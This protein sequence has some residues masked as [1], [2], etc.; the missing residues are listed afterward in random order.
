MIDLF[1]KISFLEGISY[2]SLF[3]ISMPM[4]YLM[5]NEILMKP[6]GYAHGF[7]FVAYVIL[8]FMIKDDMKWNL[9]TLGIV[10]I[11]SLIPFGTFWINKKYFD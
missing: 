5:G 3:L 1:K 6:I 7:L 8:A 10:L 2:L 4:K 11:A 9:K